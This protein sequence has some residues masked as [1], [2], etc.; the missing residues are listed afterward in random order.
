MV[1]TSRSPGAVNPRIPRADAIVVGLF[2]IGLA[3]HSRGHF[4]ARIMPLATDFR[5]R[6][7]LLELDPPLAALELEAALDELAE[8]DLLGVVPPSTSL[9]LE[10]MEVLGTT[11]TY[12]PRH[13]E[14]GWPGC[15]P[16]RSEQ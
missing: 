14:R 10:G 4:T 6:P 1:S 2:C 8:V 11:N 12:W 9:Y 5:P 3:I 16:D 13:L 7:P 15:Q